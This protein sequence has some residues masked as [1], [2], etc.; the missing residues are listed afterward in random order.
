MVVTITVY[1]NTTVIMTKTMAMAMT[2]TTTRIMTMVLIKTMILAMVATTTMTKIF[3]K[4]VLLLAQ[5]DK[6]K[7]QKFN[8]R[9]FFKNR[10]FFHCTAN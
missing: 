3:N 4:T 2:G 8:L 7:L 6:K 1:V 10:W 5:N 9:F